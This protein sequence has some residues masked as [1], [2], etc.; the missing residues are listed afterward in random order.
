MADREREALTGEQRLR[1]DLFIAAL[2]TAERM[3][4]DATRDSADQ[5]ERD[6]RAA[7]SAPQ[8]SHEAP[9]WVAVS[10]RLPGENQTVAVLTRE[11]DTL[12]AWATYW[13]GASTGF[14]QWTF[15]HDDDADS[16]VT[17]WAPLPQQPESGT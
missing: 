8:H 6:L 17:H 1:L 16:D 4:N 10:E 11:G 7:L 9:Q 3:P 12:T 13:H 15:P 5:C 2:R 14:A